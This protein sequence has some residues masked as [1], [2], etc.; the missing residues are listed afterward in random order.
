MNRMKMRIGHDFVPQQRGTRFL[1]AHTA[2][3]SA[4]LQKIGNGSLLFVQKQYINNSLRKH[5][6]NRLC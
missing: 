3:W 5:K 2:A 6:H 1:S 4:S